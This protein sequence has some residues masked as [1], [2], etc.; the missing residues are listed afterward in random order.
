MSAPELEGDDV[1]D[2]CQDGSAKVGE[3]KLL[4]ALVVFASCIL[5]NEIGFLQAKTGIVF[6]VLIFCGGFNIVTILTVSSHDI[7]VTAEQPSQSER[8]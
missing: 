6:P 1:S 7:T 3:G 2:G 4:T 8:F 5:G